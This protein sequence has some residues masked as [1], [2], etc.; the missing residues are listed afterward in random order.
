VSITEAV[1]AIVVI[2]AVTVATVTGKM[3]SDASVG[4]YGS[5]LGYVF[6]RVRNGTETNTK[7]V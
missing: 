6:G 3:S 1:V 7:A 5:V 4:I 2:L